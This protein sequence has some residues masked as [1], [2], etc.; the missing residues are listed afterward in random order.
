[1]FQSVC[2]L[3]TEILVHLLVFLGKLRRNF[4]NKLEVCHPRCVVS[5]MMAYV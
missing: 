4:L 1:M 5:L 2:F 3:N